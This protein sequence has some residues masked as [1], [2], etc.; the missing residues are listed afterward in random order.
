MEL[1]FAGKKSPSQRI[2]EESSREV[3]GEKVQTPSPK[4]GFESDGVVQWT[5][6][7]CKLKILKL[8]IKELGNITEGEDGAGAEQNGKVVVEEGKTE[9]NDDGW[10]DSD[11]GDEEGDSDDDEWEDVGSGSNELDDTTSQ[12][13]ILKGIN[14][15][16][17]SYSTVYLTSDFHYRLFAESCCERTEM[18]VVSVRGGRFESYSSDLITLPAL[19]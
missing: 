17:I 4:A 8:F 12:Q 1:W 13:D 11:D 15:K 3:N 6:V 16:V 18:G 10:E 14:T 5:T 19:G 9:G 7:P 2:R